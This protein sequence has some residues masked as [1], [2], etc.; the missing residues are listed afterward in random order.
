MRISARSSIELDCMNTEA[1]NVIDSH[2]SAG[3]QSIH[4]AIAKSMKR[5]RDPILCRFHLFLPLP[6]LSTLQKLK[7]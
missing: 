6:G 3:R 4:L 1:S 7:I 5:L 2:A